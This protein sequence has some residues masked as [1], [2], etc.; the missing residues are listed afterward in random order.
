ML[1]ADD[2]PAS[3]THA[4]AAMKLLAL[5]ARLMVFHLMLGAAP[6]SP[7]ASRI[8]EQLATC[9]DTFLVAL[10]HDWALVDPASHAAEAPPPGL[11][12]L[13]RTMLMPAPIAS[14]VS[15]SPLKPP[16]SA[17][18]PAGVSTAIRA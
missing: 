15:F 8:A 7:R 2:H 9:A 6:T 1:L 12:R 4:Y 14:T 5:R 10:L 3:V 13:A 18:I 11:Q 16:G 17:G